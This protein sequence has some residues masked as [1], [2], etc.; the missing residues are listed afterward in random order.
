MIRQRIYIRFLITVTVVMVSVLSVQAQSVTYNHDSS[1][2]NQFLV[3][4]TGT[5]SFTPDWYY[6]AFH[7]NYRNGAMMTNKQMFRSQMKMLALNKEEGHAEALDSALTERKRVEFLNVA[8]RTPGVTDVAWQVEKTKIEGKLDL[9]KKNIEKIT[10]SGGTSAQYREWLER[11][12]ALNCGL[13]AV[14]DAY[15]PQGKR[16]EQYL[17]IYKDVLAKNVEVCELLTYLRSMR[18][19]KDITDNA[20]PPKQFDIARIARS[21]HGRWK[22]AMAAGGGVGD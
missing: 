2:M 14:R 6:D 16:K 15:M 12:N 10:L 9:L 4:E 8:D 1:V 18:S 7:K 21:A 20:K 3:G 11:Y 5:G 22:V 19:V 13:Q 17:E